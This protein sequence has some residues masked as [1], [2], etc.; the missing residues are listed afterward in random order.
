LDEGDA[1]RSLPSPDHP[2]AAPGATFVDEQ[3]QKSIRRPRFRIEIYA[4]A[5]LGTFGNEHA[6]GAGRLPGNRVD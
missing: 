2:T 1:N 6:R 3:Q 5:G 4:R